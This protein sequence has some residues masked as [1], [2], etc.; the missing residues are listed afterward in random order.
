MVRVVKERNPQTRLKTKNVVI[1]YVF[2]MEVSKGVMSK[3]T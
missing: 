2:V 3:S 1:S